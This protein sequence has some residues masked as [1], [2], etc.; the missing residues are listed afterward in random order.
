MAF[1]AAAG[2]QARLSKPKSPPT[3]M[4]HTE[5]PQNWALTGPRIANYEEIY[6]FLV[7]SQIRWPRD[8]AGC[9]IDRVRDFR[10]GW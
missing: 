5:L 9:G 1:F 6:H 2:K 8:A 10:R 7:A 4:P 3:S